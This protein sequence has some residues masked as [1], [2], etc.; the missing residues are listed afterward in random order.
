MKQDT[1]NATRYWA[2][3]VGASVLGAAIVVGALMQAR[4]Q[5]SPRMQA[6]VRT[7]P[8]PQPVVRPLTE[9]ERRTSESLWVE[10]KQLEADVARA[11]AAP[12]GR[13]RVSGVIGTQLGVPEK[14]V[15]E[16][17][18]RKVSYGELTVALALSR[19]LMKHEKVTLAKA[20]DRIL[21]LR[22]SGQGWAAIAGSLGLKLAETLE[23]VQ[24]VHTRISTARAFLPVAVATIDA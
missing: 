16:L 4:T 24:K 13:A 5:A 14:V 6:A 2:G 15:G 23:Q 17:R 1:S 10:Q 3:V 12:G 18:E 21:A 22:A 9:A 7:V 8:P 20:V 19:Q 11:V